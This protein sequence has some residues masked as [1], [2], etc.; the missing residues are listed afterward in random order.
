MDLVSITLC[1]CI[2][3]AVAWLM[4][5]YTSPGAR[6]LLWNVVLGSLGAALFGLAMIWALPSYRIAGLLFGGPVCA[7]LLILAGQAARER[8]RPE[9]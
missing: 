2:G 9:G 6:N 5:I 8:F 4:A 7:F 3:N 1:L